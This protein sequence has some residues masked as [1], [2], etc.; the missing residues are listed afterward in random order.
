MKKESLSYTLAEKFAIVGVLE[1]FTIGSLLF[2]V[3]HSS[4]TSA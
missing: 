3:R 1:T 4:A 2:V